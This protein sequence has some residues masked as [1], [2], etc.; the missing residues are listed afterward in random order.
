[1]SDRTIGS[2]GSLTERVVT[3]NAET[4]TACQDR[5]HILK[6]DASGQG[7]SSIVVL[8]VKIA[9]GGE[10]REVMK[11]DKVSREEGEC[12]D[13]IPGLSLKIQ[14]TV[15]ITIFAFSHSSRP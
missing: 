4:I 6:R 2:L 13:T 10:Y 8:L 15:Y 3:M 14:S 5:D 7:L 1:M 11:Y 12:G 9:G